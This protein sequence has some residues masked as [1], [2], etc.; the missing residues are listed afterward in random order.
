MSCSE[1]RAAALQVAALRLRVMSCG[2]RI[3]D[4]NGDMLEK[5][6]AGSRELRT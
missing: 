4:E 5:E 3:S 6:A 1:E 2:K